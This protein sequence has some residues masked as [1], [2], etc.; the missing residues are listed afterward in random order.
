MGKQEQGDCMAKVVPKDYPAEKVGVV[1]L[2]N[3]LPSVVEYS[4]LDPSVA[5][6]VNAATGKLLYNTGNICTHLYSADFLKRSC[7]NYQALAKHVAH[8]VIP[9]YNEKTKTVEKPAE[10]NGFK[11]EMFVFD[12]FA[13]ST[14]FVCMEV[15]R[16]E[17]FLP[18]KNKDGTPDSNPTTCR[19]GISAL[20]KRYLQNAGAILEGD[21]DAE[22]SPL[23]SYAGE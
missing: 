14:N 1:A 17:E 12:V 3:D 19:E 2:R 6:K 7:E 10:P 20:H 9:F 18:L 8:K 16:D 5:Q 4:E 15:R 23:V 22:I 21:G 13:L 11:F